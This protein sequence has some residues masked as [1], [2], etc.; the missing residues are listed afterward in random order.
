MNDAQTP[1]RTKIQADD[2]FEALKKTI[3]RLNDA[4][5]GDFYYRGLYYSALAEAV[6]RG[7][8]CLG[9]AVGAVLVRDERVIGTG[10]NGTPTAVRN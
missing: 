7:A 4:D 3:K 8:R 6:E 5:S 9:L 1:A 10:Y 2:E